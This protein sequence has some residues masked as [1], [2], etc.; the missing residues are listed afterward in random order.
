MLPLMCSCASSTIYILAKM[1]SEYFGID[2]KSGVKAAHLMPTRTNRQSIDHLD[3]VL[4]WFMHFLRATPLDPQ[5]SIAPSPGLL[6]GH[7]NG[8]GHQNSL[9]RHLLLLSFFLFAISLI[10]FLFLPLPLL[11]CSMNKISL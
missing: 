7:Y 8:E 10:S 3:P 1:R 2:R 4:P 6:P 5:Y 11:L 9:R